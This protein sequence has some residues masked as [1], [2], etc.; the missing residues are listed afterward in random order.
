M[1]REQTASME[2]YLEAVAVLREEGK[3]V[4]VKQISQALGVKMPSVTAA[5]RKL[6]DDGLVEHQP[7]GY[8]ELTAKGDEVA[9]DVIHRHDVLRRFLTDILNI[10]PEAARED[11]CHMEHSISAVTL[12]RLAMF[13]EFVEACPEDE[14][15]WLRNYSYYLEHGELPGE[16]PRGPSTK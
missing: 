4:R 14:P 16:C 12:E 5:L 2:D 9:Q 15:L 6:S 3:A 13:L 7:Y 10:D 11:A 8:V 1:V